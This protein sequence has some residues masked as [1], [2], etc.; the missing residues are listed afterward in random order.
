MPNEQHFD[1]DNTEAVLEDSFCSPATRGKGYHS[2][3]NLFR[4]REMKLFGKKQIIAIVLDGNFPAM[5]VHEKSGLT[6]IFR[7][8]SDFIF[9]KKFT[10]KLGKR[11]KKK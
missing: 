1:I 6:E 11:L 8:K 9:G 2:Q 10:T 5:K 3:M 7:F 4:I